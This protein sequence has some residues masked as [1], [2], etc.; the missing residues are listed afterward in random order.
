[1]PAESSEPAE[2]DPYYILVGQAFRDLRGART[3]DELEA[4]GGGAARTIKKIEEG[5]IDVALRS[6]QALARSLRTTLDEVHRR[7]RAFDPRIE[8]TPGTERDRTLA[9]LALRSAEKAAAL[10]RLYLS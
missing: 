2:T 6:H 5:H 8:V 9:E 4:S 10:L 1:M 7:A 3:R